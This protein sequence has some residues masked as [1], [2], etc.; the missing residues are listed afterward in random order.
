MSINYDLSK[1]FRYKQGIDLGITQGIDLGITQGI[2]L[3]EHNMAKTLV[4]T[5]IAKGFTLEIIAEL[6]QKPI[7]YI[8]SIQA[9]IAQESV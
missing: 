3:G 6:L 2:D 9:E 8:Q 1:D 5:S 7:A 4:R